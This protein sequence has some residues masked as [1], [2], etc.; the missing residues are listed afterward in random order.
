MYFS[1]RSSI[2]LLILVSIAIATWLANRH[3]I[4][5]RA[6]Q[7]N[8]QSPLGYYLRDA[9]FFGTNEQGSFDVRV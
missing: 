3:E 4:A 5:P 6:V 8:R 1:V 2:G 9:V 7:S